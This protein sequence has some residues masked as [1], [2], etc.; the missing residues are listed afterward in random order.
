MIYYSKQ[1]VILYSLAISYLNGFDILIVYK[2]APLLILRNLNYVKL[3]LIC[4]FVIII[5]IDHK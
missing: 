4:L 2:L 3:G 5:F 1:S